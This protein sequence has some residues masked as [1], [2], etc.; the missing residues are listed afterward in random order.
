MH[1]AIIKV[2]IEF[3][4]LVRRGRTH[5][6]IVEIFSD[7]KRNLPEELIEALK[8]VEVIAPQTVT[9]E[10]EVDKIKNGMYIEEN[11]KT[12]EGVLIVSKGHRVN[13]A[14]RNRLINFSDEGSIDHLIKVKVDR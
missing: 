7:P 10:L 12:K 5:D 8:D 6:E 14:V 13:E 3:D 9:V 4:M 11:V 2:S 1:A